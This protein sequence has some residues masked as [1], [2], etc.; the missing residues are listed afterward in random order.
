MKQIDKYEFKGAEMIKKFYDKW[1]ILYGVLY[2]QGLFVFFVL[3][4]YFLVS[5]GISECGVVTD[6]FIRIMFGISALILMKKN[7]QDRFREQFTVKIPK[8]TW[9]FSIP[10]FV[11]L[12]LQFLY[13][14]IAESLTIAY[15]SAFVLSCAQQLATGFF[16][17]TAS[18]G[19]VMSGMLL[20]WKRTVRGRICIVFISGMLFGTLHILNVL[21]NGDIVACLWQSLYSSAFGVFLAS[22]YLHSNNIVL[23]MMFHAIW[24]IFVRIP[25]NFCENIQEGIILDFIYLAQD[26]IN[27]GVFPFVAILICLKYKP[28][29]KAN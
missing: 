20:K 5:T 11:Y 13:L 15:I 14:P 12:G 22:I 26:I 29:S 18:K 10:F 7:Y 2:G 25:G 4:E 27:L 1:P 19:L 23:C 8:S 9:L 21:F 24:D 3:L 16:E 6:S 28:L 17:E